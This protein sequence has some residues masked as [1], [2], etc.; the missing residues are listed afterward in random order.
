MP[1]ARVRGQEATG[2]IREGFASLDRDDRAD[3]PRLPSVP[4]QAPKL[5]RSR[6][7]EMS[8]R[9]IGWARSPLGTRNPGFTSLR[10]NA[11][12]RFLATL[13]AGRS[14]PLTG[15]H[16]G[17]ARPA[18]LLEPVVLGKLRGGGDLARRDGHDGEGDEQLQSFHRNSLGGGHFKQRDRCCAGRSV[19][20]RLSLSRF[21][22]SIVTCKP[23]AVTTF[24]EEAR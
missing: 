13:L 21:R 17:I 11:I 3:Q 18:R 15:R 23:R 19:R 5:C 10:L 12:E 20:L 7:K 22:Y 9:R 2:L 16:L 4:R 24:G 6:G 14:R 8:A 1:A